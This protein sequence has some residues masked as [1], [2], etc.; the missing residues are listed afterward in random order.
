M[1]EN[2]FAKITV[3]LP[4]GTTKTL[5]S[6]TFAVIC[7]NEGKTENDHGTVEGTVYVN[8]TAHEVVQLLKAMEDA[9][10]SIAKDCAKQLMTALGEELEEL[11]KRR[12]R[13]AKNDGD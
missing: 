9:E 1:E 8:G 6:R 5:Q 2:R 13:G 11:C 12:G 3:E 7:A 4:D 10:K